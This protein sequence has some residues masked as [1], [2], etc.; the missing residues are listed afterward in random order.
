MVFER[1]D[2][3]GVML[4]SGARRLMHLYGVKPGATA[5]VATSDDQGYFAALDLLEAGIR[6]VAVVDCRPGFPQGVEAADS[7]RSR[8]ILVLT[9]HAVTRAEGRGQVSAAVVVRLENGRATGD[10]RRFDC[11]VVCM[12]GGFQPASSL[13][14][15][16]GCTVGYDEVLGEAVPKELPP[17]LHVAGEVTGIHDL[18]ASILQGKVA[19]A[20]AAASLGLTSTEAQADIE[21]RRHELGEVEAR[22]RK[23]VRSDI[24][25]IVPGE[26]TRRFICVCEDVTTKDVADAIDEGFDD[27]QTLKRY[28][29]VTMGPCQ[30]K[31]CLKSFVDASARHTGRAI[32]EMG[33]TTM[34][35]PVQPV[36]LGALAGP[37]HMPIKRTPIDRKHRQMGATMVDLGPWRRAYGYGSP[38]D[39]CLA[40]RERVGII[41]V[42]T[43]GK[44]D[45]RGRDAPLLLD[46]VYTHRFSD[47]RVGRIRYGILCADNGSILDDGT[48]ARMAEDH[49]F[50]TTTTGNIEATEEW[51]KWWTAGTGMCVHVTNVTSEYAAINVAGPR[52]RDT[53]SKLTEIDLSPKTFRYMRWGRGAVAGVPAILLRIG[54]VGETG[55]EVHFPAELGEYMWDTLMEAGEEFGIAP[56]GLEA[57]RI[58]RLEKKHI[59]VGQDTDAMSNPLESDMGW[60]VRFDKED[61][62]G[63]GGL[64][65]INERGLRNKL[66]GFIMRDG[67][68]PDD[69][70]PVVMSDKPVGRVTS[71][72]LSPTLRKGFGLAWVPTELAEEGGEIRVR[73]DGEDLPADVTLSPFYDPEGK[74]LRE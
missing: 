17:T 39:E 49:Y 24:R 29:T 22:Y 32:D 2:L 14:G 43:L 67:R 63:R 65:G 3:P 55:W 35:P 59:I 50:V 58:L 54:F 68:V 19:G 1:N 52:A 27:I 57:Q 46:K 62:I 66:V 13:L 6:I 74:R 41:D 7:L 48:V 26:G 23:Q 16:S 42:S 21:R 4:S 71:S 11:E 9:S 61:F 45:V 34:R 56:F 70:D 69:G 15:Q 33:S 47:L 8:G 37:S 38:Q 10:E 30:G 28:S 72:R 64:V 60:V 44:L 40:V 53:L 36:L 31:M 73:V 12:C 25:S 51:F 5:V 20:E 18:S